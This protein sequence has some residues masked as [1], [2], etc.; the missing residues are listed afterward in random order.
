M[1]NNFDNKSAEENFYSDLDY[2]ADSGKRKVQFSESEINEFHSRLNKKFSFGASS[3][4]FGIIL[5]I[6][7]V[8]VSVFRL[9]SPI[10][11][12]KVDFTTTPEPTKNQIDL[13]Q[14]S[15][16]TNVS[17]EVL[18]EHQGIIPLPENFVFK[19]KVELAEKITGKNEEE[20]LVNL[21]P[22]NIQK[23]TSGKKEMELRTKEIYN[24]SVYDILGYKITNYD[25]YYFKSGNPFVVPPTEK[26]YQKTEL[27]ELD[28]EDKSLTTVSVLRDALTF[29]STGKYGDCLLRLEMLSSLNSEDVNS[30]F[31]S[32]LCNHFLGR[33]AI[34][35]DFF[36]KI[37]KQ[38]NN[39]FHQEAAFYTALS[40]YKMEKFNEARQIF[41]D[42][43]HEKGF[44]AER[45]KEYVK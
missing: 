39:V 33:H 27:N 41:A 16:D 43:I 29:L 5:V 20:I 42:I 34:A 2:L 35:I 12:Q 40:L 44:Y 14:V 21:E 32:G 17:K 30:I 22:I 18:V 37:E 13:M 11:S 38:A 6:I 36:S 15:V 9:I 1:K 19:T 3:G 8:G 25:T 4:F 24:A 28:T 26:R 45:A 31:Y 7:L 10:P 23:V